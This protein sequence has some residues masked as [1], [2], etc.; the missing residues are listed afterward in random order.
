MVNSFPKQRVTGVN[1]YISIPSHI[2]SI[3]I[4]NRFLK[5]CK[6]VTILAKNQRT[7]VK[8]PTAAP[9]K[10]PATDRSAQA[11]PGKKGNERSKK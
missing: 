1:K 9:K 3:G 10:D 5:S 11:K 2:H 6:K 4:F 8:T 7:D